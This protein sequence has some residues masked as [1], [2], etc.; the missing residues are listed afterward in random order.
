[1]AGAERVVHIAIRQ[2]GQLLGEI[3]DVLGLFLAE[4][5]VLE[6]HHV[7]VLHRGDGGLRVLAD[8]GIVIREHDRL[9]QILAQARRHRREGE[10]RLRAVL[11]L[12]EMAAQDDLAAVRDQLLDRRQRGHDALVVGDLAILHRNIEIAAHKHFLAGDLD[13][14]HRHFCHG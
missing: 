2:R 7:A 1:M 10:L 4:A 5:G 9:A 3:L 8:N 6:Q 11:R 13:V 12:A 14:V